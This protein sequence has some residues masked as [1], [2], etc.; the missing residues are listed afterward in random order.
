[1]YGKGPLRGITP[2]YYLKHY[3]TSP[4]KLLK[5]ADLLKKISDCAF[6]P[7]MNR[8]NEIDREQEKE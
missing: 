8:N 3:S 7:A 2:K 1:M 4:D 6:F 5:E